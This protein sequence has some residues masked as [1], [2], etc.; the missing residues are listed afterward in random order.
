MRKV[1]QH[2]IKAGRLL[3]A[4][5]VLA[6]S[7][8]S[9][10]AA[11]EARAQVLSQD[12][13]SV[14]FQK[15]F[16]AAAGNFQFTAA[17]R[18]VLTAA[19]QD[20]I[21]LLDAPRGWLSRL[22][23]ATGLSLQVTVS[24][25][26]TANDIVLLN[27]PDADFI[28]LT[29]SASL[30]IGGENRL[31]GG[32]NGTVSKNVGKLVK[33]EGYKYTTG[34]SGALTLQFA[35]DTGALRAIQSLTQ[36]V[37]QDGNAAGAHR[38]LPRGTGIDYPAYEVR[39]I[40]LDVASYFI[41][42]DA[43]IEVMEKMSMHKLNELG[44][45]LSGD[46]APDSTS[47]AVG[48][49]RLDVGDTARQAALTPDGLYYTKADWD[50]MEAAAAR[51]GIKLVPVINMYEH[52]S[53][54]HQD[55]D[56][57]KPRTFVSR[58]RTT[59]SRYVSG[60]STSTQ[61]ILGKY[62]TSLLG[63]YAHPTVADNQWFKSDTI[64][65]GGGDADHIPS[66]MIIVVN[67]ITMAYP[68]FKEVQMVHYPE[69]SPLGDRLKVL[70]SNTDF[71]QIRKD[72]NRDSSFAEVDW[73]SDSFIEGFSEWLDYNA[74]RPASEITGGPSS[75]SGQ[76]VP[77][78]EIYYNYFWTWASSWVDATIIPKGIETNLFNTHIRKTVAP[79]DQ[80]A[81]VSA[82]VAAGIP[83]PGLIGWY[84]MRPVDPALGFS[85]KG[86]GNRMTYDA[87]RY[88][89]LIPVSQELSSYGVDELY[90]YLDLSGA[91]ALAVLYG[92]GRAPFAQQDR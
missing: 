67:S 8:G 45:Q 76:D 46:A 11:P 43:M 36:I 15:D 87:L 53:A 29:T 84:S 73:P 16:T 39:R 32:I 4:L 50:K 12:K 22:R 14:L 5:L 41:D 13:S 81:F 64:I 33:E 52:A 55:T 28:S 25:T 91:G 92:G 72:V 85:D 30:V 1:F 18:I 74:K 62:F 82:F 37:M 61:R 23:L 44:L 66:L 35:E 20:L 24:G 68:Q 56:T 58:A 27:N 70:S 19:D 51:Y 38:A 49:F 10:L 31:Y 63:L 54:W 3:P 90:P 9:L 77:D 17:S 78:P 40:N 48:Y 47:S 6:L 21:N 86:A 34:T 75:P 59:A 88:D 83:G 42:A 7:F 26:H 89:A 69:S 57:S 80:E 65:V 2:S 60:S 79:A 71:V